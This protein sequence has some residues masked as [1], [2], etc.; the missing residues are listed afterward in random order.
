MSGNEGGAGDGGGEGE[1]GSS[2]VAEPAAHLA[3]PCAATHRFTS[4]ASAIANTAALASPT[5]L[6]R[7]GIAA[8]HQGSGLPGFQ[9]LGLES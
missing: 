8:G 6:E 1:V 9:S 5:S 7:A 2:G 3:D 4:I